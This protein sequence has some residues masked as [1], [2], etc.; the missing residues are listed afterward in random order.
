VVKIGSTCLAQ[1]STTSF[2]KKKN[3]A[4]K[5]AEYQVK[6]TIVLVSMKREHQA[7]RHAQNTRDD[8]Q[9]VCVGCGTRAGQ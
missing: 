8:I 9:G 1:R 3:L 2:L 6:K 7:T 5:A 4:N